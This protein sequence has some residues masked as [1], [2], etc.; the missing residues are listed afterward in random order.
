[1]FY[2]YWFS[3]RVSIEQHLGKM[4]KNDTYEWEQEKKVSA[5]WFWKK[6]SKSF[7]SLKTRVSI[8]YHLT[9][10]RDKRGKI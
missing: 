9:Y 1:M 5:F 10:R 3:F 6:K 2:G 7:Y 8:D 4:Q